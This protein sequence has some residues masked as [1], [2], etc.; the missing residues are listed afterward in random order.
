VADGVALGLAVRVAEPVAV[1][2]A[3]AVAVGEG[4]WLKLDVAVSVMVDENGGV[5]EMVGEMDGVEVS[6]AVEL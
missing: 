1:G 4:E 6:L 3:V 5:E 2:V